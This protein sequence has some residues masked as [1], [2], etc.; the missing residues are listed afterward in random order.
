MATLR[1]KQAPK[2]WQK[3]VLPTSLRPSPIDPFFIWG[4]PLEEL[5]LWWCDERAVHR[6]H[7]ESN[8]RLVREHFLDPL[9]SHVILK[10]ERLRGDADVL[11]S[12]ARRY[13][14]LLTEIGDLDYVV[15]GMGNDGH[16]ASL[17]PGDTEAESPCFVSQHPE[18]SARLPLSSHYLNQSGQRRLLISG[19]H[20]QTTWQSAKDSQDALRY[21]ILRIQAAGELQVFCDPPPAH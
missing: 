11:A 15:L 1:L 5:C 12:E 14:D 21:S 20:K 9:R 3:T 2:H 8:Y 17:F 19:K 13:S 10:A 18:G 7:R 4:F 16:T 6:E